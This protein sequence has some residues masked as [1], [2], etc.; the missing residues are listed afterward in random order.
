[1]DSERKESANETEKEKK[2]IERE[3]YNDMLRARL[4][5]MDYWI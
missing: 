3:R 4:P 2:E 5:L 1:M